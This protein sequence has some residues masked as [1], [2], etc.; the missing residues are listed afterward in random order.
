[1]STTPPTLST[2]SDP[3]VITPSS[4]SPNSDIAKRFTPR[5]LSLRQSRERFIPPGFN[6]ARLAGRYLVV[7]LGQQ[8]FGLPMKRVRQIV[9]LPPL[10]VIDNMPTYMRGLLPI[11]G[12]QIPVVSL[13]ARLGMPDAGTSSTDCIV[14]FDMGVDIGLIVDGVHQ[15]AS[16]A[17][18]VIA[19]PSPIVTAAG[20]TFILGVA[21]CLPRAVTLIDLAKI[22]E[23]Q[24]VSAVT[25][26]AANGSH[27]A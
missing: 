2:S 24:A 21:E 12:Q 4:S 14:I 27:F 1:V 19:P 3:A 5:V 16:F 17:Q 11:G 10:E 13:R 9:G 22:V 20:C 23:A 15:V 6:A 25:T 18:S 26:S 7:A 8:Y